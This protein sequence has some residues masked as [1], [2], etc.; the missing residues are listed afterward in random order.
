MGIDCWPVSLGISWSELV[1]QLEL[2]RVREA[3]IN[4]IHWRSQFIC[5]HAHPPARNSDWQLRNSWSATWSNFPIRSAIDRDPCAKNGRLWE[6]EVTFTAA[7]LSVF[8]LFMR[9]ADVTRLPCA[10]FPRKQI[11][12]CLYLYQQNWRPYIFRTDLWQPLIEFNSGMCLWYIESGAIV[13]I[14]SQSFR[15]SGSTSLI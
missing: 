5:W 11:I 10:K 15:G 8:L 7:F 12:G 1:V 9:R 4:W 14:N 13:K 6:R 2:G 3:S